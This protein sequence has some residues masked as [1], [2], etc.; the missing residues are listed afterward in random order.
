MLP[1]RTGCET[2]AGT[3]YNGWMSDPSPSLLVIGCGDLGRRVGSALAVQDWRI[4]A[5]RRTPDGN[6]PTFDWIA[7][8]YARAG[9]LQF[10]EAWQP[11]FVLLTLSPSTRDVDGYYRGFAAATGNLLNGLGRHRPRRLFMVS[12]TRVYAETGGGWVDEE[13]ALSTSD[14]RALAIIAAERKLLDSGMATTI[15]RSGGIYG[16]APGRLVSKV[17]RGEI[18]AAQPPRYTNRIHRE[19]CAGFLVHLLLQ[20]QAG[21]QLQAIYNA[22]DDAPAP[23]HEVESWLAGQLGVTPSATT[24]QGVVSHKRCRNARLHESGYSLRY[25]DYRAGYARVLA[26]AG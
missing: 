14:E 6:P 20:A 7:A 2:R 11:D 19:D 4:G 24:T 21:A 25:P 10:A 5:V 3:V 15:V 8:D 26:D 13:A 12:S 22:V 9:S 18:A 16:A 23:A 17:A 1:P